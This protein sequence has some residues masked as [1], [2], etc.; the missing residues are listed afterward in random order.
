MSPTAG[1]QIT[2][3]DS[4][5]TRTRLLALL[6]GRNRDLTL[7]PIPLLQRAGFEVDLV[8]DFAPI[9]RSTSCREVYRFLST[10]HMEILLGQLLA[11]SRYDLIVVGDDDILIDILQSQMPSPLKERL[12]PIISLDYADHLYSKIGLSVLLDRHRI[13][14]PRYAVAHDVYELNVSAAKIGFPLIIKVDRSGGGSGVFR[15][16]DADQLQ[17]D[18]S[19]YQY[20]I[21]V[22]EFIEGDIIDLS[23]FFQDGHLVHFMYSSFEDT[24]GGEFGPS[25]VRKYLQ[26][27]TVD[28]EVFDELERLGR[29]LGADGFV[30]ITAM[31]AVKDRRRYYIEADMR[32]NVW[33]D[34][35]RYIGN[36]AAPA[37]AD[38]FLN[39]KMMQFPQRF[40]PDFP[41]S[42]L[43]PFV[44]RLS[45]SELLLNSYNCWHFIDGPSQFLNLILRTLNGKFIRLTRQ[46]MKPYIPP[47]VWKMLKDSHRTLSGWFAGTIGR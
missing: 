7:A 23:G 35:G 10:E 2:P 30:S 5:K 14:T 21:L 43:M 42:V 8:C 25:S 13:L 39:G 31:K 19:K 17:A 41:T 18:L 6:V 20:P 28:Q 38:C 34:Y 11:Q 4:E 3:S 12:L 9:K 45:L 46:Y 24:I 22:Q 32:P 27:G 36:D 40:L 44:S 33:V 15:C 26:L 1:S 29:V 47:S 16:D 37:V